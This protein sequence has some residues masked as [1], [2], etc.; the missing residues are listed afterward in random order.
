MNID[1]LE[2]GPHLL[3]VALHSAANDD[4]NAEVEVKNL[5]EV[6]FSREAPS[7]LDTVQS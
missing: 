5:R 7:A 1:Q 3:T 4:I 2:D 6:S